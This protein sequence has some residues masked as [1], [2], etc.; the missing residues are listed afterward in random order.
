MLLS[1]LGTSIANI[2]LPTLASAFS[3]SFQNVQWVVIAY[4]LAMTVLV[5][6]MGRLGDLLGRRRL[7]LMG[8][9][10]FS[11]A[12]VACGL[13][14]DLW[15]LI[16]ARLIQGAGAAAM[17]A[18]TMAFVG[19]I[20]PKDKAGSA[21][22]LLGTMS[23]IGT[24]LGP[25]LGGVL[26]AYLGWRA[27]FL[28]NLSLGI[29]ALVMA[30]CYLPSQRPLAERS[31]FDSQHFDLGG[32][33]SLAI[34]L[35][36]YSLAVTL[37]HGNF[38]LVNLALLMGAALGVWV[39]IVIER[40]AVSPLVHLGLF[41][42]PL[43]NAGF[44]SSTLVATVIMATL[45]VGPFYL[46]GALGLNA[47]GAGLLMSAGPIVSALTGVPA[48][49][50]VD[51]F[52][53]ESTSILGLVGMLLG[54]SLLVI[55]PTH[56]AGYLAPL[57]L[58]TVGY[59]LFQVANNTSVMAAGTSDQRGLVSGMLNLSRNLGLITG[60]SVMGA[61]YAYGVKRAGDI[62]SEAVVAGMHWVF[63]LATILIAIALVVTALARR[64]SVRVAS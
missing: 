2:G 62:H 8:L 35:M 45:V 37:G 18:L 60:A 58:M 5:V 36:L 1:S 40:R 55:M 9:V 41:R 12:S 3:A 59:A 6:T 23:A 15:L 16:C 13:A 56:I 19:D 48:G 25:S 47:A 42:N 7:L 10:V 53:T 57:I 32:I 4:L 27:I 30:Y 52:G 34:A 61:V 46:T 14:N 43:L 54:A 22:G 63:T 29:V 24:A 31:R 64:F 49:R 38:G 28:I 17:M 44:V 11:L 26:I 51:R 39:F 33:S 50:I 20:V 21:M